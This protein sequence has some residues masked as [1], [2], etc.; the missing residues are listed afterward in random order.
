MVSPL[1]CLNNN[2]HNTQT[3]LDNVTLNP[4][5]TLRLWDTMS[6]SYAATPTVQQQRL[7]LDSFGPFANEQFIT[8]NAV[9]QFEC[10]LKRELVTNFTPT[11]DSFSH[12][13]TKLQTTG[14]QITLDNRSFVAETDL[15]ALVEY[16]KSHDMLPCLAFSLDRAKCEQYTHIL[17]DYYA[18]KE[19]D[20]R[21]TKYKKRLAGLSE[22]RAA[23]ELRAKK[24]RDLNNNKKS[25][26]SKDPDDKPVDKADT[27][28]VDYSLLDTYL[29]ECV[30]TTTKVKMNTAQLPNT[31]HSFYTHLEC[32]PS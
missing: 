18:K 21:N 12:L 20:L 16:L 31:T 6:V 15:P 30:L 23:D 1:D 3:I 27:S 14:S 2:G 8:R 32:I 13:V 29:D 22:K 9:Q 11:T 4:S 5:D 19:Q 24:L 25:G 26:A 7:D 17:L 28:S 10:D